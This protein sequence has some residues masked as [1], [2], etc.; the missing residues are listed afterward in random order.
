MDKTHT[1][2]IYA[3]E[4]TTQRS[5]ALVEQGELISYLFE[6]TEIMHQK[7]APGWGNTEIEMFPIIGPTKANDF[8][9]ATPKGIAK[10]D[11]HGILRALKYSYTES[12]EGTLRFSKRYKAHTAVKNPKF[13]N[14]S[15]QEFLDWPYDFEFVKTFAWIG[16]SLHITFDIHCEEGMPIMLGF[17]PAFQIY[18]TDIQ[19]V[20]SQSQRYSLQDV[21]APGSAALPIKNT[22][23]VLVQNN[24]AITLKLETKG[25]SHFMLWTEVENMVCIEPI[26]FYPAGVPE[27]DLYKGFDTSTGH[28]R[29]EM[30]ISPLL[31]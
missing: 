6:K 27:V 2:T 21:L 23:Q 9:I 18:D 26:T 8:T 14:K 22:D 16:E 17:H 29:Y 10:L 3:L 1:N 25:F 5:K 4:S 31:A 12:T 28:D 15:T 7:G 20:S 30:I 24:G 11:Q 13:P 19:I